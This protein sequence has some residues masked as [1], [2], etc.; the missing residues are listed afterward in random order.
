[1][2]ADNELRRQLP[3]QPRETASQLM[4]DLPDFA[5]FACSCVAAGQLVAEAASGRRRRGLRIFFE[6]ADAFLCELKQQKYEVAASV[7]VPDR[8][9]YHLALQRKCAMLLALGSATSV[10]VR[11]EDSGFFSAFL[12]VADALLLAPPEAE[13]RV[14]WTLSGSEQ[15]FTYT[16]PEDGQ[17]VWGA[18]FAPL[19]RRG[20]PVAEVQEPAVVAQRWNMFLAASFRWLFRD[21]PFAPAQRATYRELLTRHVT[22]THPAVRRELDTLG[23][24]LAAGVA[25]GVHKRVHTPGTQE[26]QGCRTVWSSAQ[27]IEA[28]SQL[29][30]RSA[31]PVTHIFLATDDAAAEDAFREA[32]GALLHVRTGVQRVSGGLNPDHTL[33]EVHIRSPYNPRCTLRDAVDVLSDALLLA[34]CATVVHMDSNV[35]SAVALLNPRVTMVHMADLFCW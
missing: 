24:A 22:L 11:H 8:A 35:T 34:K 23:A 3:T 25:I 17:C 5:R 27:F 15:H 30:A 1:M 16:P 20:A 19:H 28:T 29:R 9:G 32:F 31:R 7:H 12:G 26:Y 4:S 6:G 18:L 2:R 13:L 14:D 10:V 33:N 21:S